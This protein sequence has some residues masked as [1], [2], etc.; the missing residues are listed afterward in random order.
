[1]RIGWRNLGRNRRRSILT[2]SALACGY[3]SV[4]LLIGLSE[5]IISEM[6]G[7]ATGL[8]SG[9]L[10]I[11]AL[12]YLP[13]RSMHQT[14]GGSD[15]TDIDRL[16]R[17]VTGDE[18]VR[19]AAP[20]V[21]GGGLVSAGPS[22]VAAAIIGF[23]PVREPEVSR[24][25]AVVERGEQA[26]SGVNELLIGTEMARRLE[27]EPG[28]TVVVVAP[29]ADGSLGNDLFT[30]AGIFHTGLAELD[31]T[32][33]LMPLDVLQILMAFPP[34]RV[35]EIAVRID[36][37]WMAPDAATRLGDALSRAGLAVDVASWTTYRPELVEYAQLAMASQ[38]VILAIVFGMAIFGVANTMLMS[39]FE[40]RREFA[41]MLALGTSPLKIVWLVVCEALALGTLSLIAGALITFPVLVWWHN[42]PPD[43]SRLV[44]GFT[45]VGALV[46]PIL[47]VEYPVPMIFG[48]AAA[49]LITAIAATIY[50][51][52]RAAR[53]APAETLGGR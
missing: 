40:R 15:G 21:F 14:I 51:A 44:G 39:T 20:R 5:G 30:V 28:D 41:L 35:H 18:T 26:S 1:M 47:R 50:P 23:D 9:Q 45:M 42:W 48:A 46:R 13:E 29:A 19:A 43:L 34:E 49:L 33:A 37:P 22:T 4:V 31:A 2:A 38:W 36:D 16:L 12:E 17:E 11:H 3:F 52:L 27:A 53:V 6:I 10:Q 24:I 25:A 8:V 7:N 32:F